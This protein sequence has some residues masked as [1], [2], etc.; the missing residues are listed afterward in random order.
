MDEVSKETTKTSQVID[1]LKTMK[2]GQR[3]GSRD[4][5]DGTG[6]RVGP[7]TGTLHRLKGEGAIA[8][9]GS[10][11]DSGTGMM[12]TYYQVVSLDKI[13]N[14]TRRRKKI[15]KGSPRNAPVQVTKDGLVNALI[16]AAASLEKQKMS[17]K[18]YT[19]EE[20][21]KEL[22]SRVK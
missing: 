16:S 22:S 6:L 10:E 1:Y 11:R 21:M 17:L 7:V 20:L 5:I 15:R 4:V 13:G 8:V 12:R 14:K 9:V 2:S 18:D 19:T 3:F